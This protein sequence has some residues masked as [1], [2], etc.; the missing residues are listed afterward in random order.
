MQS[1]PTI[2]L[3]IPTTICYILPLHNPHIDLPKCEL[4]N[5]TIKELHLKNFCGFKELNIQLPKSNLAVFIGNNGAGKTSV[6]KSVTLLLSWL[7]A[8]IERE[9]GSGSPITDLDIL[10]GKNFSEIKGI[11]N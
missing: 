7:I 10:N 1:T 3:L 2:I 11:V 9:K 6:L 8:R 4:K 5:Y